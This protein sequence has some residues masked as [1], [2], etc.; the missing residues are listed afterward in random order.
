MK[1]T[2]LVALAAVLA[3]LFVPA[4]FAKTTTHK[5]HGMLVRGSISALDASA[6]TFTVKRSNGKTTDLVWN[7]ATK[8]G[9]TAPS[10]GE[11]VSVRYMVKNGKNVATV[12]TETKAV[13]AKAAAPAK[14]AAAPA[15]KAVAAKPPAPAAKATAVKATTTAKTTTKSKSGK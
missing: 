1:I 3:L 2:R 4:A 5:A 9:K 10:V 14:P 12:I 6:K 7:E 8:T 11:N 15:P 13:A